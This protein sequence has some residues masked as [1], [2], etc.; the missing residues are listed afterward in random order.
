MSP[1]GLA[2]RERRAALP[3]QPMAAPGQPPALSASSA[4]WL[5]RQVAVATR[6]FSFALDRPP[7]WPL[8]PGLSLR[9]R[10]ASRR[11]QALEALVDSMAGRIARTEIALLCQQRDADHQAARAEAAEAAL[12]RLQDML[13]QL[14]QDRLP[15][16]PGDGSGSS[17][18]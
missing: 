3:P 12:V 9:Q 13:D 5:S 14:R 11:E 2:L 16:S 18:A 6:I 7:A 1:G 8:A 10:L 17:A 4:N 15:Q